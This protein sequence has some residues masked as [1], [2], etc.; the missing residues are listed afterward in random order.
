MGGLTKNRIL[1]AVLPTAARTNHTITQ[2]QEEESDRSS[3]E[4]GEGIYLHT[5]IHAQYQ[6]I[7]SIHHQLLVGEGGGI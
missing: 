3:H 7:G 6:Q 1:F 5:Y 2:P 4:R